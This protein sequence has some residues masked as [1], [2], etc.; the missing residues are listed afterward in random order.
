MPVQFDSTFPN[1]TVRLVFP[2]PIGTVDVTE[3]V[4]EGQTFNGRQREADRFDARGSLLLEN[5]DGRFSRSNLSGPYVSGG[6]S[7]VRP[8]VGVYI[9]AEWD[10][11][12]W[13]VFNGEVTA[14]RPDWKGNAAVEG[15]DS[16][17]LVTFTGL[18]PRI[19]A[20]NGQAVAPVGADELSGARVERILTA[21]GWTGGV[22]AATGDVR[23]QATDLAGNGMQQILDVVD[24]EGGAFYIEANGAAT[25]ESRSSLVTQSRSNT[26]QV[27]FSAAATYFRDIEF[28]DNTE[29]S[30][31]NDVTMQRE[32]G[33]PQTA[34]DTASQNL[35]GVKSYSRTGL[36]ATQDVYMKSAAEF[37]VA[38]WKDPEDRVERL[39]I[40]PNQAP[41]TMWP[42][43][44]GRR[45]HD[46]A[47]V[48][49]YNA[50]QNRTENYD[51]FIE[52]I[53]HQFSQN[54]W[55][56]TFSFSDARPWNGFSVSTWDSGLWDT[57]RWWF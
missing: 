35:Y 18:Y 46:R 33:A 19:A 25:F 5:W 28:P 13:D 30:V 8:K 1:L 15:H 21:A 27:T 54:R 52:G 39:T 40:N 51:L 37:N 26:S 44:L 43:A 6:V 31:Y 56:T 3:Y 4:Q 50:R 49:A 20:W 47:T 48:A 22:F 36:P 11:F 32:G 12:T 42:H 23:M 29:G 9:T 57:A 45:I 14:F 7:F 2:S 34:A 55:S 17:C 10:A 53:A 38:R 16:L 41:S 24:T